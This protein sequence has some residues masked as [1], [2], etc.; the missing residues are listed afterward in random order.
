M[1]K[2][3]YLLIDFRVMSRAL[4]GQ[5]GEQKEGVGNGEVYVGLSIL[6][7]ASVKCCVVIFTGNFLAFLGLD[8]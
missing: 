3:L 7:Y 1:F 2:I 8:L 4:Q 6:I 5:C